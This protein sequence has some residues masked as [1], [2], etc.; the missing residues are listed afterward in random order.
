MSGKYLGSTVAKGYLER[1]SISSCPRGR[2]SNLMLPSVV[3]SRLR[4]YSRTFL[5][6]YASCICPDSDVT[7][8]RLDGLF[9]LQGCEC[10]Q[11]LVGFPLN[12]RHRPWTSTTDLVNSLSVASRFQSGWTSKMTKS[13]RNFRQPRLR[14]W[15][16]D[17]TLLPG[18][19]TPNAEVLARR[20]KRWPHTEC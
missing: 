13:E 3:S 2:P 19:L 8:T 5:A 12:T 15:S 11:S 9:S 16:T 14:E 7:L 20:R 4:L 10:S 6:S 18:L 17:S 1:A